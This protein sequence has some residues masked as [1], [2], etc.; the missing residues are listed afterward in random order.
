MHSS[1]KI[2]R[3][4]YDSVAFRYVVVNTRPDHD[5][6][7]AFRRRFLKEVDSLFVPVPVQVL[8]LEMKLLKLGYPY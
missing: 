5:T 3:A 4:S 7:D 1:R 6:L 8:M 2:E